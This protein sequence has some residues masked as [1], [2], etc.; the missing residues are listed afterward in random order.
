MTSPDTPWEAT[1]D[2]AMQTCIDVF[3]EGV[4]Q[5]TIEQPGLPP[6]LVDGIFDSA[7]IQVD[8]D[9]GVPIISNDPQISFRVSNLLKLLHNGDRVIIRGVA[10]QVKEPVYDGQGTVTVMLFRART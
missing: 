10:Y 1:V 7:S 2:M 8:P 9:T 3:G 6:Y 4:D 5:V